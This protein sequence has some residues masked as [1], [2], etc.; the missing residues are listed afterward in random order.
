MK[1]KLSHLEYLSQDISWYVNE[2]LSAH[3]SAENTANIPCYSIKKLCERNKKREYKGVH[4]FC[5]AE[6]QF[7]EIISCVMFRNKEKKITYHTL[8]L[9]EFTNKP[10]IVHKDIIKCLG[11][12]DF[13]GNT[14]SLF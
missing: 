14:H 3:K 7:D 10:K 6:E 5:I 13:K 9:G 8:Y 12:A 2:H 1:S 4:N 11:I